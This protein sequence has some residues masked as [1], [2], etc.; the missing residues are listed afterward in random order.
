MEVRQ[1]VINFIK[2]L[3]NNEK[4]KI[5]EMLNHGIIVGADFARMSEVDPM[6]FNEDLRRVLEVE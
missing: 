2:T 1:A 6:I 5:K 3:S 4:S